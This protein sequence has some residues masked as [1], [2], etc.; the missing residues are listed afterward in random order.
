MLS[1]NLEKTLRR[2]LALANARQHEY[3]TLEHL[4]MALIDDDD[5]TPVL[6]ACAVEVDRLRACLNDFLDH[7]LTSLAVD[8][9]VDAK[10][11]SGFQ[12]VIQRAAIHVESSGRSEVTGANVLVALFSERESH[13]VF[14]LQEQNMSRLDAVNF[15]SHGIAKRSEP[16][17]PRRS[18]GADDCDA[19]SVLR[20]SDALVPRGARPDAILARAV[21]LANA[22]E[23]PYATLDHLLLALIDDPDAATVLKA[24]AVD[25]D[26]MRAR[27]TEVLDGQGASP[28][29]DAAPDAKP[30]AAVQRAML[31]VA[32]DA[33]RY[34]SGQATGA[35]L[36]AALFA[37]RDYQ[38]RQAQPDDRY[39]VLLLNDGDASTEFVVEVLKRFFDKSQEDA[40]RIMLQVH[41]D[42][43]G[44]AGV[45]MHEI[46][47]TKVAQVIDFA[48]HNQH[49]LRCTM[50]KD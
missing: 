28:A 21:A 45:Y 4:L 27:L 31:R 33:L 13:A 38:V 46:A 24:S 11:A 32:L 29:V 42:G 44:S 19:L 50:E 3:A 15:I 23:H 25:V 22:R 35:N 20:S 48:R 49:P 2:A 36:L 7:E 10:P 47:E 12:R 5:A 6:K 16:G 26:R 1:R 40:A 8:G 37:E 41:S 34:G 9:V 17:M 43:V 14:F 30:T 18:P 39:R